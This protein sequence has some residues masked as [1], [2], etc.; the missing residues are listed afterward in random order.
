VRRD[1]GSIAL[2]AAL[3][4]VGAVAWALQLRPPLRVDASPLEGLPLQLGGWS[5]VDVPLEDEVTSMLRADYNVQRAYLHPLGDSVWLYVGYYG[6]DR[7]GRPEHTPGACYRAH[8][9]DIGEHRVL[10]LDPDGKLRVNEFVV[11]KD[12]RRDLVHFWFQSYRTPSLTGGLDQTLDRLVGRL[13]HGRADGSLVRLSTEL[14]PG[15]DEA[16]ARSRLAQFAVV[17]EPQL[18]AHWPQESPEPPR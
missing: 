7:G 2:A 14:G 1:A 5:A 12:G 18:A 6:T 13:L 10:E 9:W 8:G 3:V 11:E 4:A 15:R 17:L 16:T